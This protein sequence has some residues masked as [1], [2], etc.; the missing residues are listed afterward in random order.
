MKLHRLH[1]I[2]GCFEI[3]A[4][5]DSSRTSNA[6]GHS[7]SSR[8]SNAIGHRVKVL[9]MKFPSER[10]GILLK[11]NTDFF[12]PLCSWTLPSKVEGSHHM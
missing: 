6:I 2:L 12:L 8:T 4:S 1:N 7:D 11:Y 5:S 9:F 3:Y 10:Y